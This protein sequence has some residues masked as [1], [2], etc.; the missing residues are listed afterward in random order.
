[1][2]KNIFIVLI[3]IIS[4]I[5]IYGCE[6]N[7][8]DIIP[9]TIPLHD[10]I[11]EIIVSKGED[12]DFLN[13]EL[14][15]NKLNELGLSN[16]FAIGNLDHDNIPEIVSFIERD[17][18]DT[19]DQGSLEVYKFTGERYTIIDRIDMNYDNTNYLLVI[20]KISTTQNGILL[21]NQVGAN[22]GVTYGY[23]LE[24]G[25]LKSILNDRKISLISMNTSN[26]IKDVD[27]DGILEF[28]IFTIDPETDSQTAEESDKIILWYKWN[29][30]DSGN[31]IQVEREVMQTDMSLMYIAREGDDAMTVDHINLQYLKENKTNYDKY[32]L[33]KLIDEYISSLDINI[34]I[35]SEE[36]EDLF[37]KYQ[38]ENSFD[39]LYKKYG[40]S[41]E[42][43]ND[44]EY[45]KREKILQSEPDLKTHLIEN[46]Q[47]GYKI[48]SS[49]GRSF[50]VID[51]QEFIDNFGEFVTKEYKHYLNIKAKYTNELFLSDGVLMISRDKLSSRIVEIEAFKITYPY[52]SYIVEVSDLYQEYVLNFIFGNVN[53]P[54][55]DLNNRYSEGS[56]AIFQDT[57]NKYP[58]SYLAE[59]LQS[60]IHALSRNS[61]ILNDE[62]R[63]TIDNFIR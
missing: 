46:L 28:S 17:P 53:S 37:I 2:K 26:E 22:A 3:F 16:H 10:S 5:F 43:L 9:S 19:Q 27:N 12:Y 4:S 51:N 49:E 11:K 44:I 15:L 25:K 13:D 42:R 61:N 45:L 50:Y 47:N 52:S 48:D 41:L 38:E 6:I 7:A 62:M 32:E 55:Y 63:E 31:L 8:D 54:N 60:F 57:I 35:K 58:E 20:G 14:F 59:L 30:I 33:S 18:D 34:N 36:L 39:F 1:M 29:G 24:N 40:L 21:S 23:I 56:I